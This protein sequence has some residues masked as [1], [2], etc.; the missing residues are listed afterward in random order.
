MTGYD[1][2]AAEEDKDS[3][4]NRY[5]NWAR[6]WNLWAGGDEHSEP[7]RWLGHLLADRL[8]VVELAAQRLAFR[9]R[10]TRFLID[11][12]GI[13][14]LLV[15]DADLPVPATAPEVHDLAHH[16]N[17]RARV[18]YAASDRVVLGHC[19]AAAETDAE[20]GG[21]RCGYVVDGVQAPDRMFSSAADQLDLNRPV[22]V[23]M[24]TSLDLLNDGEAARALAA[25][26]DTAPGSH[27]AIA[28][29]TADSDPYAKGDLRALIAEYTSVTP[30]LR[31]RKEIAGFL[32]GL[33]MVGP[34]IVPAPLWR[35]EPE[36]APAGTL[37][38]GLWCGVAR[39]TDPPQRRHR[40]DGTRW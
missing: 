36:A 31:T 3:W 25:A 11:Q 19:Q 26:H 23:L 40:M 18:V 24:V 7:D 30:T 9:T 10:A 27:L 1:W 17:P 8:P 15:A 34:G 14:Q 39:I 29:L 4:W 32:S 20:R 22:G 35:P 13:D 2:A 28:H 33:D 21:P 16:L 12:C 5:P 38:A 37:G 6:L